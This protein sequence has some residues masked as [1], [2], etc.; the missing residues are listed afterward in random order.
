VPDAASCS[1]PVSGSAAAVCSP[2]R[3]LPGSAAGKRAGRTG[4]AEPT[5]EPRRPGDALWCSAREL[6]EEEGPA[7]AL[8]AS[9]RASLLLSHWGRGRGQALGRRAEQGVVGLTELVLVEQTRPSM[10][11]LETVVGD[12]YRSLGAGSSGGGGE[13]GDAEETELSWE[14][15]FVGLL[16]VQP[17]LCVCAHVHW[18]NVATCSGALCAICKVRSPLFHFCLSLTLS[19]IFGPREVRSE[20]V[21]SRP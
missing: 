12:G 20:R 13:A 6:C 8:A 1:S 21:G 11:S 2:H 14:A 17:H 15:F 19:S 5:E 7:G 18:W 16:H 9:S 10:V 4:D 3:P